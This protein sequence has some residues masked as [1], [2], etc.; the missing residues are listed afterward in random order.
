MANEW[1]MTTR[2]IPPLDAA[3]PEHVETVTFAL[4]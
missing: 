2:H 3:A 1:T 4:G